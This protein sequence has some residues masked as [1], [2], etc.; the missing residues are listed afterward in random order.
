M[1]FL[2][3]WDEYT[4]FLTR[5]VGASSKNETDGW[6]EKKVSKISCHLKFRTNNWFSEYYLW[7]EDNK[8]NC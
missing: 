3:K 5:C 2:L 8:R 7:T 1:E 4:L 6:T